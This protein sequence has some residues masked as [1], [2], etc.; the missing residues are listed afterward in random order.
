MATANEPFDTVS[1]P[2]ASIRTSDDTRETRP[3]TDDIKIL[4][5]TEDVEIDDS[6]KSQQRNKVDE[7]RMI[8]A[9]TNS[10]IKMPFKNPKKS[11]EYSN[12]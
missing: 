8:K 11:F 10:Q 1:I 7:Y 12:K 2:D 5:A 6:Q 4:P 9:E 3:A